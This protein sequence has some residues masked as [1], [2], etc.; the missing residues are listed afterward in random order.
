MKVSWPHAKAG[1]SSDPGQLQLPP[2]LAPT[3]R[4]E[5]V[6]Q[7]RKTNTPEY[8]TYVITTQGLLC[9]LK[10]DRKRLQHDVHFNRTYP[11][12]TFFDT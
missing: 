3:P 6:I 8:N 9:V 2:Q 7:P 10:R 11:A 1:F 12:S 4:A 5:P